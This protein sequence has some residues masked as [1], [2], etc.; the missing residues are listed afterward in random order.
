MNRR[1]P[2]PADTL[3]SRF[4]V[5][6]SIYAMARMQRAIAATGLAD[7]GLFP[8]Q[9]I[10]LTELVRDDG[11]SQKALAATM[12]IS[13]VTV[14]K[15][16]ARLERAGLVVRRTSTTDRRVSL[17]YLTPAGRSAQDGI[18]AVWADL[19]DIVNR[20]LDAQDRQRYLAAAA[21][22][23]RS[24]EASNSEDTAG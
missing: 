21:R 7:L 15:M 18:R 19:E 16:T 17:V 3:E 4:P 1:V 20:D 5:S 23:R 8:A 11:R 14:A 2:D 24:L 13:H 10:L 6:Y 22:I 12:G 9:E